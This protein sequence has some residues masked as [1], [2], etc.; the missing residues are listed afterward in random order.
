[1]VLCPEEGSHLPSH[2][3]YGKNE[4]NR[5]LWKFHVTFSFFFSTKE[6][7]LF[8]KPW[9]ATKPNREALSLPYISVPERQSQKCKG[10]TRRHRTHTP[11]PPGLGADLTPRAPG[12]WEGQQGT[13]VLPQR[14]PSDSILLPLGSTWLNAHTLG[15]LCLPWVN[16]S[17][18]SPAVTAE[19]QGQWLL[20]FPPCLVAWL[21][22]GT[23][24]TTFVISHRYYR[25]EGIGGS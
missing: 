20:L 9:K 16:V 12:R 10:H 1:M 3:Y 23:P 22:K 2:S 11:E 13:G 19:P 14:A 25:F 4:A 17:R 18:A 5:V 15:W 21:P 24:R 8:M 7:P 6:A